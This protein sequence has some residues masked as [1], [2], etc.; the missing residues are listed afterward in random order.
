MTNLNPIKEM[1]D[2]QL[3]QERNKWNRALPELFF[4]SSAM[5]DTGATIVKEIEREMSRREEEG[6][7]WLFE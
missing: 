7:P 5:Y 1:T 2:E 4:K 6:P 3:I